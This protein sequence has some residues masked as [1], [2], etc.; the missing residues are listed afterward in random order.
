MTGSATDTQ[1]GTLRVRVEMKELDPVE[2]A[3]GR[4]IR[5]MHTAE[6][7]LNLAS[8]VHAPA[9]SFHID[10]VSPELAH[11]RWREPDVES[12]NLHSPLVLILTGLPVAVAVGARRIMDEIA[13]IRRVRADTDLEVYR[14]RLTTETYRTLHQYVRQNRPALLESDAVE[15]MV[16]RL[17]SDVS[18]DAESVAKVETLEPDD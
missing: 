13:A 12:I 18:I 3:L 1:T 5:Q 11:G 2:R 10:V 8:A 15:Q 7:L 4:V 16:V 9:G 14:A 6:S 17:I